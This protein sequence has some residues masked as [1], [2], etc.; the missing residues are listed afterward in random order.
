[1]IPG[2]AADGVWGPRHPDPAESAE[3][4]DDGTPTDEDFLD[5]QVK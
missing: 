5:P 2:A 3:E 1:M 4:S